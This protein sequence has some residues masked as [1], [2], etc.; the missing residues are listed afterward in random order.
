MCASGRG[1][2]DSCNGD[3]G[4][5][6]FWETATTANDDGMEMNDGDYGGDDVLQVGLVSWGVGCNDA[7][8]PGVCK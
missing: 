4:G 2:T 1:R 7:R 5:P 6:L 8:Y 3:S